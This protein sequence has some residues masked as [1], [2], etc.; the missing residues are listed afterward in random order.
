[1]L[2]EE[3]LTS[4]IRHARRCYFKKNIMKSDYIHEGNKVSVD[5]FDADGKKVFTLETTH[6]H[7]IKEA[8][9]EALEK[10]LPDVDAATAV[11]SVTNNDTGVTERYRLNAHGNLH[12]IR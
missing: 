4:T 7:N 10:S 3:R 11:F 6:A 5:I 8:V 1:M 12:L 9:D 2:S